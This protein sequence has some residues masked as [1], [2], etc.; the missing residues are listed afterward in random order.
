MPRGRARRRPDRVRE[1]SHGGAD[2][3][4]EWGSGGHA[5]RAPAGERPPQPASRYSSGNRV[6]RSRG[7]RD[8]RRGACRLDRWP[9]AV[10]GRHAPR[11]D[12]AP[13]RSRGAVRSGGQV[14]DARRTDPGGRVPGSRRREQGQHLRQPAD[15]GP[16]GHR[17]GGLAGRSVLLAQPR[18]RRRHRPRVAGVRGRLSDTR[19]PEPRIPDG[20]RG[21][22]DQVGDGAGVPDRRR[23]RRTV[24][25]PGRHLRHHAAQDGRGGDRVP[26]VPRQADRSAEPCVVRG[27][28]RERARPCPSFRPRRRRLVPGP[29]QL[30]AR[31][32]LVGTPRRRPVADP[33]GGAPPRVHA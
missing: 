24:A 25:D 14:P 7:S 12:R 33:A 18:P 15:H 27:D 8:P 22:H 1:P 29:G 6:H 32:R 9:G 4:L 19:P 23:R 3:L 10:P 30:Q 11:H 20:A 13:S 21:R 26:G 17:T 2:R 5:G 16:A 28:A 31:E